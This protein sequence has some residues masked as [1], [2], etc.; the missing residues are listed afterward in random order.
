MPRDFARDP[1]TKSLPKSLPPAPSPSTIG[2]LTS[3]TN[4]T[5]A[6]PSMPSAPANR[7]PAV[8]HSLSGTSQNTPGSSNTIGDLQGGDIP[9]L[10][11]GGLD[12]NQ[13][14]S[15]LRHLPAFSK[16]CNLS[17]SF[18]IIPVPHVTHK[19][20]H[21]PFPMPFSLRFVPFYF[22]YSPCL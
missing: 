17:P 13:I 12:S 14:M 5:R 7:D 4:Y 11:L 15:I 16:V 1:N 20:H 18:S 10:Q 3:G 2:K 19:I 22:S 6:D 21:L 9:G 8:S